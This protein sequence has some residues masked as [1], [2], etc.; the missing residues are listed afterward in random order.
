MSCSPPLCLDALRAGANALCSSLGKHDIR[1]RACPSC[2][3]VAARVCLCRALRYWS[4]LPSYFLVSDCSDGALLSDLFACCIPAVSAIASPTT[5]TTA[6]H[7]TTRGISRRGTQ[8]LPLRHSTV[9]CRI[10]TICALDEF[11]RSPRKTPFICS[12]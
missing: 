6:P 7:T 3:V 1:I 9:V 10:P 5:E 11:Q 4:P 2:H 12:V 8:P